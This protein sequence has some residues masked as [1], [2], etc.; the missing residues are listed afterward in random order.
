MFQKNLKTK[1]IKGDFMKA[2]VYNPEGKKTGDIKLPDF[3]GQY[4]R[5]DL[6]KRAFLHE[7]SYMYQPKGIDKRAGMKTSARYIGRKDSYR[8]TKNKGIAKLPREKLPEGRFGK[9]RKVPQSVGGRRAHP[10]N[11]E[12]KLIEKMNKREYFKALVNSI[13]AT[14]HITL[15]K[16]RGH[17]FDNNVP[18]ILSDEFEKLSKTKDIFTAIL[19]LAQHDLAR[20]KKGTKKTNSRAVRSRTYVPRSLL[21]ITTKSSALLKSA[22]NI[23]GV[24]VVPVNDVNVSMLAP[25]GVPAR[26]TAFTL[27]AMN[28]LNKMIKLN[29]AGPA[30]ATAGGT[31]R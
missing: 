17:K 10:P 29:T 1:N 18:I 13:A 30:K 12:K 2:D 8:A 28:E 21:I 19:K 6:I 22:K 15:V 9:V 16:T 11:V 26:L 23:P 5:P 4:I 20:S 31:A 14:S 3:F 27:S 7:Q 25:G 24:D